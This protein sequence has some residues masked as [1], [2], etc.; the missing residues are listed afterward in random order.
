MRF[1]PASSVD[2]GFRDSRGAFEEIE[3]AALVGLLL[4]CAKIAP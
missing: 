2:F 1:M 3:V 4:R